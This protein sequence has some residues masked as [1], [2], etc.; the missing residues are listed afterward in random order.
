MSFS[1]LS[2]LAVAVNLVAAQNPATTALEPLASKHFTY[3]NIPYQ[4][5]GDQGGIRGPQSGFNLCNSTTQN[6]DSKCQVCF[7]SDFDGSEKKLTVV[8]L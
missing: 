7:L 5:T 1:T 4:V 8:E 2:L 6:Q 3:P